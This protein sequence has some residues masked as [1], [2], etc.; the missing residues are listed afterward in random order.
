[1]ISPDHVRMM[2]RYNAWQNESIYAAAAT[3]DDAARRLDRGAFFGSI[4][5]TLSHLMWGDGVWMHRFDGSPRPAGGIAE[6]AALHPEWDEMAARRT[7]LDGRIVDWAEALRQEWLNAR[8][9][10]VTSSRNTEITRS[11]GLLA[12]HFFNHQAHHRGQVHAMLTAA[13]ARPGATDLVFMD[14]DEA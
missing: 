8:T 4:H 6:S 10:W 3:L 14:I 13:G 9:T 11:N 7:R 12:T 2:A 5:G 1:V